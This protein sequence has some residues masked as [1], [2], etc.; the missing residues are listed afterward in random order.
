MNYRQLIKIS[1]PRFWLYLAGPYI[2]GFSWGITDLTQFQSPLFL[3]HL[4]FFLFPANFWVYGINDLNDQDTDSFNSKKLKYESKLDESKLTYIKE[5]VYWVGVLGLGLAVSQ[6]ILGLILLILFLAT[7][8]AY[9]T[10][11]IRFKSKPFWDSFSNVLY[12]LP[13]ILGYFQASQ[14]L[15]NNLII[16]SSWFWAS[17]MHLFSAIPDIQSD[18]KAGLKTSAIILGFNKSLITCSFLWSV[19]MFLAYWGGLGVWSLIGIVYIILPLL[20][21]IQKINI[22][23]AYKLF[24]YIN[25]LIGMMLFWLGMWNFLI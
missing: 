10:K 12:I 14:S 18:K 25:T 1:R 21:H 24:P 3:F 6:S 23:R 13:G 9:S 15:P 4:L 20:V 17:S 22:F 7:S 2:V 16:L 5:S 19:S 11:L 8:W